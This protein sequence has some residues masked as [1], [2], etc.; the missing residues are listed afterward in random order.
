VIKGRVYLIGQGERINST[1]DHLG[2]TRH[3]TYVGG[4]TSFAVRDREVLDLIKTATGEFIAVGT[5]G[6]LMTSD[7]G[8]QWTYRNG[9]MVGDLNSVQ[10][11]K[12]RFFVTGGYGGLFSSPDGSTWTKHRTVGSM[13]KLT[14]VAWNDSIAVTLGY[15]SAFYSTDLWNWT[16]TT[17]PT[18]SLIE[19]VT[20][21]GDRFMAVGRAYKAGISMDGINWIFA[22][23]PM[24]DAYQIAW[25]GTYALTGPFRS[26]DGLNW[27]PFY[28]N[29]AN[30]N[31]IW[32]GSK[33]IYSG[34]TFVGISPDGL[35]GYRVLD[36]PLHVRAVIQTPHGYFGLIN[37]MA[38]TQICRSQDGIQW[39]V[40]GERLPAG[41]CGLAWSGRQLMAAGE[42]GEIFTSSKV[43]S[44][45]FY[46]A[47]NGEGYSGENDLTMNGD[48]NDD[49]ISNAVAYYFGLPLD[50]PAGPADRARLP[51]LRATAGGGNELVFRLSENEA[52]Y[53]MDLAI[54]RSGD[55]GAWL[56]VAKRGSGGDWNSPEVSEQSVGGYR[57]V[58]LP[59]AVTEDSGFWRLRL[60][61]RP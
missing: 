38:H 34:G 27:T 4:S 48:A 37:Q 61:V 54:E 31:P 29:W 41:I 52:P 30:R 10:W 26:T 49:G 35:T 8:L 33:F 7:D 50:S 46:T 21:A 19:D 12:D 2:W 57:E 15:G 18:D 39:E 42:G 32:D 56:E 44:L 6:L 24:N 22:S 36:G 53:F 59:V 5:E 3:S 51:T 23:A 9:G 11:V 60:A 13:N 45:P 58:T 40:F 17:I 1:A 16:A 28:E 47:L 20:W 14:A 25:N 55:L 43:D